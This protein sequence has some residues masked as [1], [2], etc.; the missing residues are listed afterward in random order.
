ME[1]NRKQFLLLATAMVAGCRSANYGGNPRPPQPERLVDAGPIGHYAA[2]GLYTGFRDQGF[3]VI[4]Q[5]PKLFVLSAVC[6]HRHCKL[7]ALQNRS[8]YCDCHGSTFNPNGKVTE[9][10][11]TRDLP[12]LS[13]FTNESGRLVVKTPAC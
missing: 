6:T 7:N 3:F 8:F 9:G 1:M 4:R 13:W 12:I 11:A 2:D 5:G 10:P